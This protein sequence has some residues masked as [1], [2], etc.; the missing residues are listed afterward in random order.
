MSRRESLQKKSSSSLS[1]SSSTTTSR[2][3]ASGTTSSSHG[4]DL[5]DSALLKLSVKDLNV[6]LKS[7]PPDERLKLKK[8]RRILKNRGYAANCRTKRMS[9]KELLEMEKDKL[10]SD[11]K[12]LRQNNQMMRIKLD[13]IKERFKDL[14]HYATV[15]KSKNP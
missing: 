4:A 13:S 10:D 6:L 9:Q 2:R 12:R 11:V 14:Q 1:S 7:L 15:L 8:K 5:T 3:T